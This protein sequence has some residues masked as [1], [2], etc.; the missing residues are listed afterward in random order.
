MTM[1]S[2]LSLSLAALVF[3]S[4]ARAADFTVKPYRLS[5]AELAVDIALDTAATFATQRAL[6][7]EFQEKYPDDMGVQLKAASVLAMDDADALLNYYQERAQRNPRDEVA[8]YLTGRMQSTPE[9]QRE[10]AQK[11]LAANPDGYWG[12]LLLASA[13]TPESD[14]E[15]KNAEAALRKAIAADNSLPFAVEKLGHLLRMRGETQAADAVYVKL[16]QMQPDRFEPVQ[17]RIMLLG[18]DHEKA[19]KLLGEFLKGNPVNLDALYTKAR[20]ERELS[21]WDDHIATMRRVVAAKR[22]GPHAYDLACGFSLGGQADSA[23]AWLFTAVELG[24]SDIEQYKGDE[25]LLPLREDPRWSD[26]L[27]GVERAEQEKLVEFMRQAAATAPQRK[28][29]ALAERQDA[30]APE[31]S[32]EDLNGERVAL[33][34]LRGKVVILD[35]WATWCGPCRKTMPLLDKFY[36]ESLPAGVV[37]YGMNVWER[38]GNEKVK[39][40]I[41]ERGY[42]FPILYGTDDIAAAYGV[43]GIPTLVVIDQQGK[44]AYRHIGYDPTLPEV[45]TW[46]TKELLKK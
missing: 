3:I 36:T 37:V 21:R 2:L 7:R 39:P 27:S 4:T 42:K 30:E 5:A 44:I 25:D 45:L 8:V 20:A 17:Y 43:R 15:L 33:A 10:W 13:A 22:S 23:Y 1:P 28:K 41:Q 38:G 32:V 12:N 19:I 9:A 11:L 34:E 40:Y 16:G 46:Q 26:L 6:A 18:G 31:W 29:E 24:F 14:P 35:F